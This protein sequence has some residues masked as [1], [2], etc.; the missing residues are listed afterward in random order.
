MVDERVLFEKP[1]TASDR[2]AESLRTAIFN[3]E[4]VAGDAVPTEHSLSEQMNVSRAT[5]REALRMLESQGLIETIGRS[6]SRVVSEDGPLGPFRGSIDS[7]LKVERVSLDDLHVMRLALEIVAVREAAKLPQTRDFSKSLEAIDRMRNCQGDLDF[8]EEADRDFHTGL[9]EAAGNEMIRLM[10]TVVADSIQD[11]VADA[12]KAK[13][14][15]AREDL[16]TMA[17]EHQFILNAI[18]ASDIELATMLIIKH[19]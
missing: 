15:F 11:F 3:G 1:V 7:L 16:P 17:E 19:V 12:L 2:V 5:S 9:M 18:L 13:P 10:M 8:F 6:Q 4:L 14:E